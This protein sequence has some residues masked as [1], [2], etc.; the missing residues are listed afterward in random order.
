MHEHVAAGAQAGQRQVL[1][2]EVRLVVVAVPDRDALLDPE[3]LRLAEAAAAR[4]DG[5][6][7]C[8]RKAAPG[9]RV[10][11]AEAEAGLAIPHRRGAPAGPA[12][13]VAVE[14]E[15]VPVAVVGRDD[16]AELGRSG[17]HLLRRSVA[18]DHLVGVHRPGLESRPVRR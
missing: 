6:R 11:I 15:Q 13:L 4:V 16:V 18:L 2:L 1:A 8:G 7:R 3:E 9:G 14:A 12:Q 17:D 5:A 10:A